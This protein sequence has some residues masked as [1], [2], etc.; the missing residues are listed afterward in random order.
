MSTDH[1]AT[2]FVHGTT[3]VRVHAEARPAAPASTVLHISCGLMTL[4]MC[5]DAKDMRAMAHVLTLAAD[6]AEMMAK[7]EKVEA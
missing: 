5:V 1:T 6:D 3:E 4:C 2:F 7:P